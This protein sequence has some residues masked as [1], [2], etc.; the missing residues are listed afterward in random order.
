M[1]VWPEVRGW[2]LWSCV[3]WKL[4][5]IDRARERRSSTVSLSA[6]RTEFKCVNYTRLYRLR[7]IASLLVGLTLFF[8]PLG[9]FAVGFGRRRKVIMNMIRFKFNFKNDQIMFSGW[10]DLSRQETRRLHSI[11]SLQPASLACLCTHIHSLLFFLHRFI[12]FPIP[13]SNWNENVP[14]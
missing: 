4:L 2:P 8:N 14:L 5:E 9:L 13:F 10:K 7:Y 1:Y 11:L 12:L 3:H 6:E